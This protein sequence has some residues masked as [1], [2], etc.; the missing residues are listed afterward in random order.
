MSIKQT[1]LNPSIRRLVEDGFEVEIVNQHLLVHSIPYLNA[2]LEVKLG[3]L[4][5]PFSEIGEQDTVPN[6]HTMWLQG[7]EPYMAVG[8]PMTQVV[9]HSNQH[10]LFAGFIANHYLSNKPNDQC[11]TN[12]YDKV[13]HYHTLFIS[14]ARVKEPNSDGRTRIIH[15]QRDEKSVFQYPDT[16]SARVGITALTQKFENDKVAVIG[17]GGTG[18]YILDQLAKTPIKEIHLYDGDTLEV[19]N[20]FRAPGAVPFEILKDKPF[21]VDYFCD[22]YSNMHK[23]IVSHAIFIDELNISDLADLDFVFLSI[24]RG[25]SR[26]L[27]VEYLVRQQIP[28]IDVGLG[29]NYSGEGNGSEKL[30]GSC[31][32]TLATAD[33]NDHL[34][35]YLELVDEDPDKA[36]YNSN[37]QIAEMNALN[38]MLAINKW[39]QFKGFYSD[40]SSNTHHLVYTSSMQSLA[41]SETCEI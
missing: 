28:F 14:Q 18:G 32:V 23:G 33:K 12:F 39:K 4:A 5:C 6:D 20:A 22:V 34:N 8:T 41:R 31:R 37:I 11:F 30:D 26:R 9:N 13:V 25:S 38:A 7:E 10:E 36:L 40:Q 24:D 29:I 17:L 1:V 3:V 16:A 19:H 27:I 15:R 2:R 35:K 21:K